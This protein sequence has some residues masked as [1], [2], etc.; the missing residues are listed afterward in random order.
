MLGQVVVELIPAPRRGVIAESP[1]RLPPRGG[2]RREEKRI[3]LCVR[4]VLEPLHPTIMPVVKLL[5]GGLSSLLQCF[6]F[7]L[8][9]GFLAFEFGDFDCFGVLADLEPHLVEK[10]ANLGSVLRRLT[11]TLDIV[12]V[13]VLKALQ[14]GGVAVL[15]LAFLRRLFRR[16]FERDAFVLEL[17][18]IGYHSISV[19]GLLGLFTGMVMVVQTGQTM[20]RWGTEAYVSEGVALVSAADGKASIV[21]G[22]S[23]GSSS[24]SARSSCANSARCSPGSSSRGG[25][26]R[27]SP[28]KSAPWPSANR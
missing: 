9:F 12:R 18:R 22:V 2:E 4:A 21:V 19:V 27:A 14:L 13:G 20:K 3:A 7:F 17:E 10:L 11:Q 1:R 25:S 24:A 28:P 6:N 15:T 23:P 16:P 5:A 26:A 8:K